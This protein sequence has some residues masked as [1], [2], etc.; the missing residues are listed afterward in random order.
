[1][2]KLSTFLLILLFT[3]EKL[4]SQSVLAGEMTYIHA[5]GFTYQFHLAIFSN[6]SS[7]NEITIHW[8]DGTL[9]TLQNIGAPEINP[10]CY[11][12]YSGSHTYPVIGTYV[13][14]TAINF[15][16]NDVANIVYADQP[17]YIEDSLKIKDPA[18]FGYNSSP[19]IL[20]PPIDSATTQNIFSHNL[21]IYDPDGDSLSFLLVPF[22]A[23]GYS[24][25]A[26]T[27][28]FT[29]NALSGA[30]IWSKP[31]AEGNYAIA[32]LIKEWRN[33]IV[34]GTELINMMISVNDFPLGNLETTDKNSFSLFPN[35]ASSYIT[36][37][38]KF[39]QNV[40]FTF[41]NAYGR[42][43]KRLT[44]YPNFSSSI[45]PVDDL[46]SGVYSVTL[47]EKDKI[48]SKKLLV[49]R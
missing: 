20:N 32:I 44:F 19:I 15:L 37:V 9:D 34:I 29:V 16:M 40:T 10:I 39:E 5:S 31:V 47:K 12:E 2:K 33:E 49:A 21:N 7:L 18:I 17:F 13:V 41:T 26:A 4:F 14:S 11:N 3:L 8:G 48:T 27:D 38:Y 22:V 36:I 25:P 23:N 35:P 46:S 1:M 24:F 43:I 42:E 30:L 45:V 28:S 6:D